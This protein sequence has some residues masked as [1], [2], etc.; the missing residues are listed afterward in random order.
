[1]ARIKNEKVSGRPTMGFGRLLLLTWRVTRP[2]CGYVT[3]SKFLH[4][5]SLVSLNISKSESKKALRSQRNCLAHRWH[6]YIF[7]GIKSN[8]IWQ[9]R[10]ASEVSNPRIT[11]NKEKDFFSQLEVQCVGHQL[12]SLSVQISQERLKA[13]RW[14]KS[15]KSLHNMT[16]PY[17]YDHNATF[18]FV[19]LMFRLQLASI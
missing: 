13:T 18:T 7:L 9:Q 8:G 17:L 4:L 14:L 1:M 12:L 11:L 2:H 16:I 3:N 10:T 6:T 5:E 15:V 19:H